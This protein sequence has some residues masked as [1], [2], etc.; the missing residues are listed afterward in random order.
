MIGSTIPSPKVLF[1]TSDYL[2]NITTM[3]ASQSPSFSHPCCD[4][5]SC[6]ATFVMM[7]PRMRRLSSQ[8]K[9]TLSHP[10]SFSLA[11]TRSRERRGRFH[12]IIA[13]EPSI[14]MQV[15]RLNASLIFIIKLH[16]RPPR[17]SNYRHLRTNPINHETVKSIT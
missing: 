7:R 2:S 10:P 11:A 16:I 15:K 14:T 1:R 17:L 8:A 12:A 13:I 3:S 9:S 6:T 5:I 4:C